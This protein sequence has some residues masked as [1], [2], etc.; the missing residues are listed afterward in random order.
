MADSIAYKILTLPQ[1]AALEDGSFDGAPVD[2]ADGYIH[3]STAAQ[4]AETLSRHFAGQ[5]DLVIAAVDLD[6]LGEAVRWEPSRGGDLFPHIYGRLT[7][8]V[9]IAYGPVEYE[10]D[11]TLKLPVAG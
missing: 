2:Q 7:L 10:T 5:T 8:D 1:W 3:L 9:V 6:A 11:G 4:A